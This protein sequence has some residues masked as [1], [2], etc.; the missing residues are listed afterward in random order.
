MAE[1]AAV[2]IPLFNPM[3][4]ALWF[5][6]CESTFALAVPKQITDSRTKFNYCVAH[7]PPETASLVRDI[8]VR[9]RTDASYDELKKAIIDRCGE[10]RTQEIR[11][12]ITGEQLGDRKP[13]E[14]LRDMTRRAENHDIS[15]TLLLEL[16]LQQMPQNV[17][18]IL[19][20]V[21]PLDSKTAASIADRVMEVAPVPVSACSVSSSVN[22]SIEE[23][24]FREIEKLNLRIDQISRGRSHSRQRRGS[25]RERSR[26]KSKQFDQC[27]YHYK[28]G[29]NARKCNP[30]CKFAKNDSG[31]A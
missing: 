12:L 31:Q 4:P 21:Q 29:E 8:I 27:W 18:I 11:R 6:M 22:M 19:A 16:F 17:Q 3:D 15:D 1:A 23:R 26:S 10:S 7:L 30:P 28:F 2:K 13:S 25:F 24:L 20:S 14:L 5:A 9:E